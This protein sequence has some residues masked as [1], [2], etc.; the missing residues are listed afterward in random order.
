MN[1]Q[2][3]KILPLIDSPP[4]ASSLSFRGDL[5]EQ[6]TG[7]ISHTSLEFPMVSGD[8]EAHKNEDLDK[9][10]QIIPLHIAMQPAKTISGLVGKVRK[11][12]VKMPNK[13]R[14]DLGLGLVSCNRRDQAWANQS[15]LEAR[16]RCG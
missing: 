4:T 15:L 13:N 7:S 8:R 9:V 14:R 6:L 1:K 12:A 10:I 3:V 5:N 11:G 16:V 2:K